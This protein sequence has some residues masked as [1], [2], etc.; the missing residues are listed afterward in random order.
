MLFQTSDWSFFHIVE[1]LPGFYKS[2]HAARA[3][4]DIYSFST[5]ALLRARNVY[6]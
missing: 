3:K 5:V 1:L 4:A 6:W 2:S